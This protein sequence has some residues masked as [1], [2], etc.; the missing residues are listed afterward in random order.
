MLTKP[1]FLYD[2]CVAD[3]ISG[4]GPSRG[5]LHDYEPSDGPFWSTNCQESWCVVQLAQHWSSIMRLC[6]VGC[7]MLS[8]YRLQWLKLW[9]KYLSL[10]SDLKKT[11]LL[12][13][14]CFE[15]HA[16]ILRKRRCVLGAEWEQGVMLIMRVPAGLYCAVQ[17]CT[18]V[19]STVLHQP[20]LW[21]RSVSHRRWHNSV[22]CVVTVDSSR[23]AYTGD[24]MT[25]QALSNNI[26]ELDI[27]LQ[28]RIMYILHSD[29]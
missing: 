1:P 12:L 22:C 16:K 15:N 2:L 19:Y 29:V 8:V 20:S 9:Q 3:P 26:N 24:K 4:E 10:S 25:T 28:V 14:K 6:G 27:L 7:D 5:L 23:A 17:C 18:V 11:Y 13:T 21:Q